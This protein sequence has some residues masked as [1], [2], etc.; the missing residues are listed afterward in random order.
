MHIILR[1]DDLNPAARNFPLAEV[2]SVCVERSL[3][4]AVGMAEVVI[5]MPEDSSVITVLKDSILEQSDITVR[6]ELERIREY[7]S[8]APNVYPREPWLLH[9]LLMFGQTC[10]P[11]LKQCGKCFQPYEGEGL[12][13]GSKFCP[14]C[15]KIV[16]R[17]GFVWRVREQPGPVVVEHCCG[18]HVELST[19]TERR[20]YCA[21]CGD[22]CP[23]EL[24]DSLLSIASTTPPADGT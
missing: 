21:R 3:W 12:G 19:K 16:G 22:L 5:L 1:R 23:R 6:K 11:G 10:V 7:A 4:P 18:G 2:T 17:V 24:Y 15:W 13:D 20:P 9:L 8:Y 14:Q